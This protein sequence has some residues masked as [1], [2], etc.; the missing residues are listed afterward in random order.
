MFVNTLFD[1]LQSTDAVT[2]T[3]MRRNVRASATAILEATRRIDPA[4]GR[5]IWQLLGRFVQIGA[6]SLLELL[7][8]KPDDNTPNQA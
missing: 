4:A 2:L 1:I 8:R 7:G 3:D 6:G 5:M